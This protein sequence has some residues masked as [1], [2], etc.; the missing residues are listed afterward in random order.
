MKFADIYDKLFEMENGQGKKGLWPEKDWEGGG[1]NAKILGQIQEPIQQNE[2][3]QQPIAPPAPIPQEFSQPIEISNIL[4]AGEGDT[5][6]FYSPELEKLKHS[7]LTK[8]WFAGSPY[9]GM[10]E[11]LIQQLTTPETT[12]L[13]LTDQE[14][15]AMINQMRGNI[16][17]TSQGLINMVAQQ[18]GG[19]GFRPGESG[20]ADAAL[21]NIAQQAQQ[22]LAGGIQNIMLDEA[23]RRFEQDLALR[24]LNLNRILAATKFADLLESGELQRLGLG[25]QAGQFGAGLEQFAKELAAQQAAQAAAAQ[26]AADRLAWEKERWGKEFEYGQQLDALKLLASLYGV[27]LGQQTERYSPYWQA[28]IKSY[29]F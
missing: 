22:Q 24:N 27:E 21:S 29:G 10:Y 2:N 7:Y 17:G 13:G 9:K 25:L 15:Q 19:R 5:M 6:K 8:D 26:S 14:L 1:G 12:K 28:M 3:K 23:R 4:K 16:L 11:Q 18:M 20:L